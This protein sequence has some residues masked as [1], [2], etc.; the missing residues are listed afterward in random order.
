MNKSPENQARLLAARLADE[1]GK[2]AQVEAVAFAGSQTTSASDVA[3]D[4]DLYVY[5]RVE[6]PL[7]RR[8]EIAVASGRRVEVN[9]QFWETGDEW[10]DRQTEI[11]FDIIFAVNR[12]PHP[13]E[14]RLVQIAEERCQFRPDPLAEQIHGL[15]HAA[16]TQGDLLKH[17]NTLIDGVD[18]LLERHGLL[19]P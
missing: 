15:L 4:I 1:Y 9:N 19:D 10:I 5:G 3:S 2:A 12:L 7:D 13:G 6:I 14:K 8:R 16:S 18:A 17:V 11:H